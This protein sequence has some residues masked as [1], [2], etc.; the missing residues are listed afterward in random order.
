MKGKEDKKLVELE[1][2]KGKKG[3]REDS[4]KEGGRV[5]NIKCKEG[6]RKERVKEEGRG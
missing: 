5:R 3:K 1:G 2:W 4:V 6:K